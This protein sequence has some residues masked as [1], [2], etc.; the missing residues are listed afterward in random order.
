MRA[1]TVVAQEPLDVM[2]T[3]TDGYVGRF[4]S[5]AVL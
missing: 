4:F 3:R 5:P 1:G 2:S